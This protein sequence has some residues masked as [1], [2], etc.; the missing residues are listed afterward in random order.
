MD[1]DDGDDLT[2]GRKETAGEGGAR[3]HQ[4]S[5]ERRY[6]GAPG[7]SRFQADHFFFRIPGDKRMVILTYANISTFH[8]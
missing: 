5:P 4:P 3:W 7:S 1:G 6:P 8:S 2:E